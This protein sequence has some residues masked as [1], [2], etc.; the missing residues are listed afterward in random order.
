[1]ATRNAQ[2]LIRAAR[3]GDAA[4]RLAL[5][6]LY[7]S[8]GEG[9][10]ASPRA[11]FHW[12]A[13]AMDDGCAESALEIS[14]RIPPAA[15]PDLA[16]YARACRKAAGIGSAAAWRSLGELHLQGRGMPADPEAALAAFRKAAEAGDEAA[17][18][19]LGMVLADRPDG[20]EEARLWLERAAGN[21]DAGAG[22]RL[23][24]LLWRAGD[25]AALPWMRAA[26]GAGD[27]ESACR[28]GEMLCGLEGEAGPEGVA[29]L[30]R[31]ARKGHARALWL[32]G[33]LHALGIGRQQGVKKPAGLPFCSRKTAARLLERAAEAGIGEA[34]WDLSRLYSRPDFT[35]RDL[36]RA[37]QC[38]E[39]AAWAGVPA[40]Q[41]ALGERLAA[42]K[43]DLK[44]MLEAGRW[45]SYALQ[46]GETGAAPLLEMLAGAAP[47]RDTELERRQ[48]AALAEI[49]DAHPAV[50][51]RLRLAARFDLDLREALFLDPDAADQGWCLL[52]DVGK[53]FTYKPWRLVRIENEAQRKAL[54]RLCSVFASRK[55]AA[56]DIAAGSMRD[57]K[58]KVES[59]L[60]K[61]A[62]EVDLFIP[63]RRPPAPLP[64]FHVPAASYP[65]AAP[66]AA[67]A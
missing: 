47:P 62:L 51:A 67:G 12:L 43:G 59:L 33:R 25:P 61:F 45:L 2:A 30:E 54:S 36:V 37:R 42:H 58:R 53:H 21:G 15:A 8:G 44:S 50:A 48:E 20:E 63:E 64:A 57:R 49:E 46:A 27:M 32:Y 3:S 11:A 4:S 31:A 60:R 1:M 23:G 65:A 40:A 55:D 6:R 13:M 52:A 5:G 34:W 19:R 16:A 7:L 17:A 56:T 9:L 38:L 26:A 10:A 35:G 66:V 24:E 18:G 41:L 14:A 39:K 22:R 28:L 29:W